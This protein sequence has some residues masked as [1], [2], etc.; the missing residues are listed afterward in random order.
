MEVL[1]PEILHFQMVYSYKE[2]MRQFIKNVLLFFY[3]EENEIKTI[4]NMSIQCLKKEIISDNEYYITFIWN[5][6]QYGRRHF[7][8]LCKEVDTEPYVI[9]DSTTYQFTY[10]LD[11]LNDKEP[12]ELYKMYLS[13]YYAN[14]WFC[15]LI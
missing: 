5:H 6:F 15:Q 8:D 7:I 9:I 1:R 11:K 10:S 2:K 4:E 3:L 13:L 14:W 12:N